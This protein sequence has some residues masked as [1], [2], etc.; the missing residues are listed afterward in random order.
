MVKWLKDGVVNYGSKYRYCKTKR[1][2]ID[3]CPRTYYLY[4]VG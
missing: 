2:M 4:R 1:T 3:L